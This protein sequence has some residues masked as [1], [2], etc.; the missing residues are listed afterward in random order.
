MSA[1]SDLEELLELTRQRTT[2]TTIVL[3]IIDDQLHTY[4]PSTAGFVARIFFDEDSPWHGLQALRRYRINQI[5][6]CKLK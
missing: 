3:T 6:N 5:I 2:D 1:E 4:D